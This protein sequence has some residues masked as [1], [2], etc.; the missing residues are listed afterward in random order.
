MTQ[1]SMMAA[2]NKV[3]KWR[4]FFASWQLGTRLDTDGEYKAVADQRELLILLRVEVTALTD[5]LL[6]KGVITEAE[7]QA[8]LEREARTLDKDYQAKFPGF[9]TSQGGLHMK[10]PEAGE[11][12]RRL[13]FPP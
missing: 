13:G 12:M 6:K 10:L 7:F 3:A 9:S 4:K 11:T 2:L 1:H 8:A 5:I